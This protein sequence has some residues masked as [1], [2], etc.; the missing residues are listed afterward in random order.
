MISTD[1]EIHLANVVLIVI[2]YKLCYYNIYIN[3]YYIY[4][5]NFFFIKVKI[6]CNLI[7]NLYKI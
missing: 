3:E 6:N 4:N 2:M 7:Q 1:I 5:N